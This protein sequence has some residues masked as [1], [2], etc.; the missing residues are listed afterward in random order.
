RPGTLIAYRLR[1]GGLPLFGR[2][3]VSLWEPPHRFVDRQ[4]CGPYRRWVHLHT[5]EAHD[6]GTR[7]TDRV[8]YAVPG[9]LV[10]PALSRL[11]VTPDVERIFA[12]RRARMQELFAGSP[13]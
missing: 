12:Y 11:V 6:G 5:F 13:R 7:M 9:W 8:D 2:T 3:E 4:V 10:E 1:G